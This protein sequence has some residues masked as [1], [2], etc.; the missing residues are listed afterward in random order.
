LKGYGATNFVAR[1]A[2]IVEQQVRAIGGDDLVHMLDCTPGRN[3]NLAVS[4]L[5]TSKKGMFVNLTIG[6]D[7]EDVAVR[8]KTRYE[9]KEI[10]GGR[11]TILSLG[12]RSGASFLNYWTVGI[13][14]R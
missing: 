7:Y 10:W 6:N 1:Q 5:S 14:S 8:K 9:D 4:I 12:S 11:T 13:S 3:H 2:E